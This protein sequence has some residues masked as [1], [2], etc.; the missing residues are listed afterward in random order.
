ME[1][2]LPMVR[3]QKRIHDGKFNETD[4]EGVYNLYMLAYDDKELA[5]DAQLRA[6][7]TLVDQSCKRGTR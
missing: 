6:L 5:E 2:L 7:Q 1:M 3:A 4:S